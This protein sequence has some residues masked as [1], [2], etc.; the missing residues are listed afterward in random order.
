VAAPSPLDS[1]PAV[2]AWD[3]TDDIGFLAMLRGA[4][5][6]T[7]A[8]SPSLASAEARPVGIDADADA[9]T[10]GPVQGCVDV[11][12][13]RLRALKKRMVGASRPRAGLGGRSLALFL[14]GTRACV[15]VAYRRVSRWWRSC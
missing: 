4:R 6:A 14:L 8:A 11:I 9:S 7:D 10:A 1:P 3:D 15:L 13:K 5:Q 12:V 2:A